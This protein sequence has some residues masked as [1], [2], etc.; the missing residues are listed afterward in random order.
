MRLS[1]REAFFRHQRGVMTMEDVAR[2]RKTR[3]AQERRQEDR[4]R[5]EAKDATRG[6]ALL[7]VADE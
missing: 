4:Q 1:E 2:E 7:E 3:E 6:P 5:R